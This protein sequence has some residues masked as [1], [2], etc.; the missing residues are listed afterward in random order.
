MTVRLIRRLAPAGIAVVLGVAAG[1]AGTAPAV[2]AQADVRTV[3]GAAVPDSYVVVLKDSAT[4]AAEVDSVARRMLA[5]FGGVRGH[6]Y[7]SALR[8]FEVRL[9]QAA[10]RRLAADPAVAYGQQNAIYS[11][12]ATQAPAPSWGLDRIDQRTLP[13]SN[14]YSYVSAGSGV[15]AYIIDTGIRTSHT[16]FGGRASVGFDAIG[17]GFNGQ[18][19]NGH[20]T[21]VAGT[22]GGSTYGVAKAVSLIS[23]RVLDCGGIGSSAGLIAG[24]TSSPRTTRRVRPRWRT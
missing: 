16:D 14:S 5:R 9:P 3:R 11:I 22:V 20:G 12:N 1:A 18:D 6:T 7:H 15:K 4:P 13:L 2:A 23:V 10:A 24:S 19:C 17:D 8:G 21:H